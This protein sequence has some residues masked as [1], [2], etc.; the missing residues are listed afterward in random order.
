[1]ICGD[2]NLH[3]GPGYWPVDC[4]AATQNILL[5]AHSFHLGAVWIGIHPREERKEA[6]SKLMGLPLHVHPFALVAMGIPAEEKAAP[7]RFKE[8]RI[9]YNKWE[10]GNEQV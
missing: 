2:E 6:I 8:E 4:A 7:D 10:K 1:L 5:A 3:N 9:H